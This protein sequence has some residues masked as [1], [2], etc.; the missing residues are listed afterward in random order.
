MDHTKNKYAYYTGTTW[1]GFDDLATMFHAVE[2]MGWPVE[3]AN[4]VRL[5]QMNTADREELFNFQAA[6]MRLREAR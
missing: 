1:I 4:I 5:E 6:Q 2:D 3:S